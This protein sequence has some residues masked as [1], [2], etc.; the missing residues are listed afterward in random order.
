MENCIFCKII[1]GEIPAHKIWENDH[2]LAFLDVN[3]IAKGHTLVIPKNHDVDIFDVDKD[4]LEEIASAI[5][6]ISALIKRNLA[7]TGVNIMNAS[8]VDAQQS[9]FHLHFHI[10]PRFENDGLNTWP[11]SDFN[12]ISL[13]KTAKKIVG[14]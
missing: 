9:V 5:K 7:I 3:P 14:L 11:K 1:A 8:G 10:I 2:V 12:D 4:Y 6:E 13:E